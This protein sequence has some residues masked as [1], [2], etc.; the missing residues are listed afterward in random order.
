M[1]K[2]HGF[3]DPVQRAVITNECPL[4]AQ[5]HA[6]SSFLYCFCRAGGS[7]VQTEVKQPLLPVVCPLCKIEEIA[8]QESES[9]S[10][11]H[12]E[13]VSLQFSVSDCCDHII[14]CHLSLPGIPRARFAKVAQ[15]CC[16]NKAPMA[17]PSAVVN[18]RRIEKH[19][20]RRGSGGRKTQG[21]N[22]CSPKSVIESQKRA[23]AWERIWRSDDGKGLSK[24]RKWSD[25]LRE[26]TVNQS[27]DSLIHRLESIELL[28]D[29]RNELLLQ[30]AQSRRLL[31]GFLC[32]TW[33]VEGDV[34]SLQTFAADKA[35]GKAYSEAARGQKGHQMGQPFLS[36]FAA[37][38]NGLVTENRGGT[39]LAEVEVEWLNQFRKQLIS[40][41]VS[42]DV[43]HSRDPPERGTSTNSGEI[44]DANARPCSSG[45]C[46]EHQQAST[47][48]PQSPPPSKGD[49]TGRP[50][51]TDEQRAKDTESTRASTQ[52]DGGQVH[53]MENEI[54]IY[55]NDLA[56]SMAIWG[57]GEDEHMFFQ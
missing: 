20:P 5:H 38:V 34:A 9:S 47:H 11:P 46:T 29:H 54:D 6:C 19:V 52:E 4:H 24:Y 28:N 48:P 51:T 44:P 43:E 33:L 7:H 45:G 35:Q 41:S 56:E 13:S 8:N 12:A 42:G 57:F 10:L 16:A 18:A 39:G 1:V 30:C 40:A 49:R 3:Y 2:A 22:L 36:V 55:E 50:G 15:F 31:E 27:A 32:R 53:L 37:F 21:W 23:D 26:N 17:R 25:W 14:R